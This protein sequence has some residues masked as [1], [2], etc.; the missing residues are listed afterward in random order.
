[1]GSRRLRTLLVWALVVLFSASMMLAD[2]GGSAMLYSSGAVAI[3]GTG[4]N[5]TAAL[6]AGDKIRTAD[7]SAARISMRGSTI[8]VPSNSALMYAGKSVELNAGQVDINTS[9]GM[10][11]KVAGLTVSPAANG[12]ARFQIAKLEGSVA[13]AAERG[14]IVVSDGESNSVIQEGTTQTTDEPQA[15]GPQKKK[16]NKKGGVVL[17]P[18]SQSWGGV[19]KTGLLVAGA[20]GAIVTVIKTTGPPESKDRR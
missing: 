13:I 14:D 11:A 16:K 10:S 12:T 20:T 3:N 17:T 6:F 7:G 2:S 15:P 9:S 4:S 19:A 18:A 8:V 5:G 1:M